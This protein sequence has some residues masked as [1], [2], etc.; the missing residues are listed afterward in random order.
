MQGSLVLSLRCGRKLRESDLISLQ[1]L[2]TVFSQERPYWC[3]KRLL[4]LGRNFRTWSSALALLRI[5]PLLSVALMASST[6]LLHRTFI[7]SGMAVT[8]WGHVLMVYPPSLKRLHTKGNVCDAV[9][10]RTAGSTAVTED[11]LAQGCDAVGPHA[12]GLPA[13]A[14]EHVRHTS[15]RHAASFENLIPAVPLSA[16]ATNIDKEAPGSNVTIML[17]N[18]IPTAPKSAGPIFIDKSAAAEWLDTS[19]WSQALACYMCL[20]SACHTF[21]TW[22]CMRGSRRCEGWS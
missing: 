13:V 14:G 21:H 1:S 10:P 6:E 8:L 19:N 9:G 7:L 11:C 18:V 2:Q 3:N 17:G 22:S 4:P 15:S 12:V 5:L 16:A 20:G